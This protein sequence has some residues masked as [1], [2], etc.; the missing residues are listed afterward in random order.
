MIIANCL[1]TI[2]TRTVLDVEDVIDWCCLIDRLFYRYMDMSE[3]NYLDASVIVE[4]DFWTIKSYYFWIPP[5]V[6]LTDV[7][8]S[9]LILITKYREDLDFILIEDVTLLNY[10]LWFLDW[11]NKDFWNY[12]SDLIEYWGSY[13]CWILDVEII[14]MLCWSMTWYSLVMILIMVG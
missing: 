9:L 8:M 14:E 2:L 11:W 1:V 6:S 5:L 13:Q 10:D 3:Y 4:T 7:L 12:P